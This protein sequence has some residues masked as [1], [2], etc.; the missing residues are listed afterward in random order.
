MPFAAWWHQ[1][2]LF[3]FIEAQE[4]YLLTPIWKNDLAHGQ[5]P[6]PLICFLL[7]Q[8]A[9]MGSIFF[10]MALS[11]Q[12]LTGFS[13]ASIMIVMGICIIIYT[14][15]GGMEA[16]IWTE[17]VQGIIKTLGAL[18]ILFLMIKEIPGGFLK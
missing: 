1:N 12:A 8:F 17:V 16:V 3:H 13:M 5:E 7:T 4:K 18:L 15:F 6:M 9:R 14:V 2:I 10:G 11:L